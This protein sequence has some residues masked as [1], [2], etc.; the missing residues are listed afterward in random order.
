M[1]EGDRESAMKANETRHGDRTMGDAWVKN[2]RLYRE[3]EQT[4]EEILKH[5]WYESEK[6]GH[7][8]GWERAAVDWL[9]RHGKRGKKLRAG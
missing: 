8:I 4:R 1:L 6:A 2:T 7:D 9:V 3:W 5:K